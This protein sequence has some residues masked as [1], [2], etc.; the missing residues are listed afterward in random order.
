MAQHID[1][2]EDPAHLLG[3]DGELLGDAGDFSAFSDP[4]F[5][6][7]EFGKLLGDLLKGFVADDA[8][9]PGAEGFIDEALQK[10]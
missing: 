10:R 3:R 8:F 9:G 5:G 4:D 1:V 7:D 2:V 6:N